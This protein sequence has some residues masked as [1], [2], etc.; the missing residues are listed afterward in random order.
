MCHCTFTKCKVVGKM[1]Y[2]AQLVGRKRSAEWRW[3]SLT[4]NLQQ[5][6]GQPAA[7]RL[8]LRHE[9]VRHRAE[10]GGDVPEVPRVQSG[11]GEGQAAVRP[12]VRGERRP[13]LQVITAHVWRSSVEELVWF[14]IFIFMKAQHAALK[15]DDHDMIFNNR[16][17]R[18]TIWP[19]R[20]CGC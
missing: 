1:S 19:Y 4:S 20:G 5:G 12:G 17:W 9:E 2:S 11:S 15:Y 14:T 7:A 10:V 8:P 18:P 3:W 13:A 6:A 16:R